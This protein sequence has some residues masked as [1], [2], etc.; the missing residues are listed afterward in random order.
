VLCDFPAQ[1]RSGIDIGHTVNL[2]SIDTAS[3][4]SLMICGM[5]GSAIGGDILRLFAAPGARVP[6]LV[7]R[8]YTLPAWVDERSL[9]LV[10]SYSGTTEEALAAYDEA[11]QRGAM[12]IV[13]TSG[14]EVLR[15][16][17]KDGVPAAIIPE[18]LAPRCALGFLFFPLLIIAARCDVLDIGQ[19]MLEAVLISLQRFT[20]EVADYTSPANQAIAIAGRLHGRLPVLYGAQALGAVLLRW[21]CQ[22]EENAKRL[23]WSNV[24]PEMNHNEIMGWVKQTDDLLDRI[25]VIALRDRDDHPAV[26]RRLDVTL[27]LLRPFAADIIVLEHDD[28]NRLARIFGLLLLG[29]WVSFYLAVGTGMD[30]F[31]IENI[32]TLKRELSRL[33]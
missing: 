33:G 17:E 3:I 7:N 20:M 25:T 5:G 22:I 24:L 14:G 8:D 15:K 27:E 2:S 28:E 29:D 23:A 4:R 6:I 21:R 18:G 10:M 1:M 31:P 30:P 12:R 13:I 16:A 19:S 32:N 11:G 26:A 9:V